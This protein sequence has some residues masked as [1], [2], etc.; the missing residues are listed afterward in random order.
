MFTCN[1][2]S[3][4]LPILESLAFFRM[5]LIFGLGHI[6]QCSKI[7]LISGNKYY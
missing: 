4:F 5:Y 6:D 3:L 1:R 2:L 7:S